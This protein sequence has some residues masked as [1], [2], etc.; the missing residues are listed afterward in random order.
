MLK[1]CRCGG[2]A[3]VP[4][5]ESSANLEQIYPCCESNEKNHTT[6]VSR[7]GVLSRL[8]VA[9]VR[10]QCLRVERPSGGIERMSIFCVI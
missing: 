3:E 7:E 10:K 6:G 1:Q 2:A 5:K 4:S 8:K 9:Q